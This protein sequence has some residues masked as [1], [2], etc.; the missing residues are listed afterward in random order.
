MFIVLKDSIYARRKKNQTSHK[1]KINRKY[2]DATWFDLL[3][4]PITSFK[5]LLQRKPEVSWPWYWIRWLSQHNKQLAQTI[6]RRSCNPILNHSRQHVKQRKWATNALS[7]RELY[8]MDEIIEQ[9]ETF[10][11][12][13]KRTVSIINRRQS[14][15]LIACGDTE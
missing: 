15:S 3:H 6:I 12:K 2:N 8:D 14:Y 9:F 10:K 4:R 1:N 7:H 11:T 13:V 5:T